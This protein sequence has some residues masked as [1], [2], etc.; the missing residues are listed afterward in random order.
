MAVAFVGPN[1]TMRI[2]GGRVALWTALRASPIPPDT[3]PGG[4]LPTSIA[5]LV[6]WWNASS[7]NGF[8]D[9]SGNPIMGWNL[10]AGSLPNNC[11]GGCALEPYSFG[12]LAGSPMATPRLNGQ[13][14]G[15]GRVAGGANTLTP[16]LDPDLGFSAV[17]LSYGSTTSWTL[18]LVWSRPNW[19]QNSGRDAN[20]ITLMSLGSSP[21]LQADSY[22]GGSRLVL[23]P[24]VGE[25]V[26]SASLERRHTHSIVL[27]YTVGGGVDVWFDSTKIATAAR[28]PPDFA[29]GSFVLLHDTTVFGGAQC[30][31]HE[32]AVWSTSVDDA[33]ISNL[34]TYATRWVRGNRVGITLLVNGQSNAINYSV[35]DGAAELLAQG[36]AWYVG[37]IAY[38]ILA[39]ESSLPNYT[40]ESGHG[41]YIV[42]PSNYAGSFL[43]DPEDGSDPAGWQLGADGDAVAA[44]IGALSTQDSS[45]ICAL[46]WPW[47][48]TDSLRSYA[49]KSTFLA[50]AERFLFLERN[51]LNQPA[52]A[53][54]LVW[55]NAIP[56]G[57]NDG[58][59]MHR[60]VVL[61]LS[62]E[63][64]Q[65]VVIGNPQTTDSNPR[66]SSW[67]PATGIAIGGDSAH[68]DA[69]D[70]QRFARL[71][72]PIVARALLA[73]GRGDIMTSIPAGI[74]QVGGP[75]IKHAYRQTNTLLTL[76]IEHDAGT[77]L[78][79]P[80]QA[81]VG[82]GLAVM[83][84]GTIQNPGSIVMAVA[85]TRVDANHLLVTLGQS[86][87]NPSAFCNLY[88][89][90]GNT[91]I[92]R[93]NAVTD[94]FSSTVPPVGWDIVADLGSSWAL[95]FPLAATAIPILLSDMPA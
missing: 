92:G 17:T 30:W 15:I 28:V 90:Y 22:G 82:I 36:I 61:A 56:Y 41:I 64:S 67:N 80:L 71:A 76:T 59:Q 26:L 91:T 70:N 40:M 50:A 85:C 62:A 48:E 34:L 53:L 58:M 89:P 32:A 73:S 49:E 88:Y 68:R 6:A 81:S 10:A 16:A 21:I 4:W 60:E 54:P 63:S 33:D 25:T 23:F 74:P 11:K 77:D 66:N 18:Y 29:G 13:L 43:N 37:A 12:V 44:A 31:L 27:R 69:L 83:D 46:V 57:G 51:L 35:S 87:T 65:N 42:V 52:S 5:N 93:G 78:I 94:N 79:V 95:N 9:P 84:G 86:L 14:G 45:D 24:G 7:V 75:R 47:N 20:P 1:S 19:R 3:E 55:W 2:G 38:N 72:A 39:K 8:L